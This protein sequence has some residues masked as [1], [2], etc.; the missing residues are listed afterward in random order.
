[1]ETSL[2]ELFVSMGVG[3]VLAGVV[4]LWKRSDDQRYQKATEQREDRLLTALAANT[5][6]MQKVTSA[7][8]ALC[9]LQH[10]EERIERLEHKLNGCRKEASSG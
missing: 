10:V 5:T 7:I 9:T 4:L 3:G 8:E 6:A 2:L 1:M